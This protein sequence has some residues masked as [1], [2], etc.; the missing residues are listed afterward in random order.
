[1]QKLSASMKS[2][3]AVEICKRLGEMSGGKVLDVGTSEGSFIKTL[4]KILRDYDSFIGI[5]ISEEDLEKARSKF[6][7]E[8]V[9]FIGMNAEKM[10]FDD[11][12]FDTVCISFSIHHLEKPNKVLDEMQRVLK[13]GGH[14]IIQEMFCDDDQNEAKQTETLVHHW[15]AKVDSIRGVPHFETLSREQ[16]REL[17][18][19][20]KF[21]SIEDFE[22]QRYVKCIFCEDM[23]KCGDP[24]HKDI[25][26]F[27]IREINEILG[28]IIDH[29]RF[30]GL[31]HEAELL[32]KRVKSIGTEPASFL[33]F[34]CK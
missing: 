4:M 14:L 12:S 30:K 3:G 21:S 13:P 16:L 32:K 5:D 34:I 11:N 20:M 19:S 29:P 1:M 24:K 15:D 2:S 27:A 18:R 28:R 9:E 22:S 26:E 10:T 33:F 25:I 6:N 7:D 31:S 8:P 17:V 23:E